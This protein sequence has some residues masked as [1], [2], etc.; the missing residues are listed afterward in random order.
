MVDYQAVKSRFDQNSLSYYT[1][2][3]KAEKPIKAVLCHLPNNTP[4]QDISDG[5]VDLGFD[6]T[7]IKEMSSAHRSPVPCYTAKD[8]KIP[9]YSQTVQP[10]PYFHQGR[11]AL[12]VV[13]QIMTEHKGAVS[14]GAMIHAIT[15]TVIN[16]IK[17]TGKYSS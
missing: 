7:S 15:K 11:R 4:A 13:Q 5:L 2:Y 1:F 9:R 3:P 10:L 14:E 16:L 12:T 17:E 6:V 8:G